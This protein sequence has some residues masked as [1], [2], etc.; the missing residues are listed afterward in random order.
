LCRTFGALAF[1][2]LLLSLAS[3][4]AEN[5]AEDSGLRR[6]YRNIG[7]L[8]AI[9]L[10]QFRSTDTMWL[11]CL[12]QSN[13]ANSG[14]RPRGVQ[15][16]VFNYFDG[17]IY[18]AKD[19]LL[20]ATG[21]GSSMWTAVGAELVRR[22]LATNVVLVPLAVGAT[23]IERW[24]LGTAIGNKLAAILTSLVEQQIKLD[25]VLWDQGESDARMASQTYSEKLLQL[26]K[27]FALSGQRTPMIVAFASRTRRGVSAE[28]RRGQEIAI[29]LSGC[30]YPGP[31]L[32]AL[33]GA[34]LRHDG[35]HFSTASQDRLA[36]LWVDSL[37]KARAEQ[38]HCRH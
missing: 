23:S 22:K 35:L 38:S 28:V 5:V 17:A 7:S 6:V 1:G 30:I 24:Q 10:E 8:T 9:P 27:T 25:F 4:H 36:S 15:R 13:A 33:V 3:A 34:E 31:D 37:Q 29:D 12:G 32:D 26:E 16:N 2:A 20:G 19:P 11:L 18:P 14:D 21:R